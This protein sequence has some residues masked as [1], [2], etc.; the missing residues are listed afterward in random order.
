M[1]RRRFPSSAAS[2]PAALPTGALAAGEAMAIATGGVVP[3]GADTVV[4]IEDVE[5]RDG[6]VVVPHVVRWA[7]TSATAAATSL[8]VTSSSPPGVRL[9]PAHLGALAAAGVTTRP[10]ARACRASSWR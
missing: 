7:R 2:P 9:G 5:E 10:R 3:D 1:R 4:P 8:R 6:L